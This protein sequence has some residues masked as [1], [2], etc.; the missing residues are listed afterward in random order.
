MYLNRDIGELCIPIYKYSGHDW[1]RTVVA[2]CEAQGY[3]VKR[4]RGNLRVWKNAQRAPAKNDLEYV[5]AIQLGREYLGA[6]NGEQYIGLIPVR[7]YFK[8]GSDIPSAERETVLLGAHRKPPTNSSRIIDG[9]I[10]LGNTLAENDRFEHL[11]GK[12][13]DDD[14]SLLT[15]TVARGAESTFP[16]AEDM[17]SSVL[18]NGWRL[19]VPSVNIHFL[20]E[21][22]HPAASATFS[23]YK[24]KLGKRWDKAAKNGSSLD[25]KAF[26]L[27][28][29]L[30]RAR[31]VAAKPERYT[32][33]DVFV[34]AVTGA[35]GDP[36]PPMQA[37]LMSI[38]DRWRQQY[39]I[40]SLT[41][42]K[43]GDYWLSNHALSILNAVGVPY[44][45]KLP[46]PD[47]FRNGAFFG[48]DIGHDREIGASKIVVTVTSPGGRLIAS[49]SRSEILDE[50]IK[51]DLVKHL[52]Q[53]A[54][55]RAE[56][57]REKK[58]DKAIVF[59]DGRLPDNNI[60]KTLET[61]DNYVNAMGIPTSLVEL[62]KN[63]NPPIFRNG[64]QGIAVGA[65]FDPGIQNIRY[66]TFYE[67]KVGMA[68]TFKVITPKGGD[69]LGW[70]VD[71]YVKIL[72]GLCYT[73]S[74]GSQAH[75]PGPIY[76][77]D[78]F[79]ITSPTDNRFRGHNVHII[80]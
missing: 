28:A 67:S 58:F 74:L 78:G 13:C 51:G 18:K 22:A 45:L 47:D 36:L 26:E 73:P 1:I 54:R 12:R 35:K 43:S 49:V 62:R 52:L 68:N 20:A 69:T 2:C 76:W 19:V 24:A 79:G 39:R 77:A 34:I 42:K 57:V 40:V 4:V 71:A 44:S 29:F 5:E 38:L 27:G 37:E 6:V 17:W 16:L 8:N 41:T 30:E 10:S 14:R 55:D 59:R 15:M 7:L 25:I 66:A 32:D 75:L 31:S 50:S 33:N 46:F 64:E 60:L 80:E 56:E 21:G 9:I 53:S 48:V 61:A 11:R 23:N 70:G 72:C 65:Y 63:Q 3:E